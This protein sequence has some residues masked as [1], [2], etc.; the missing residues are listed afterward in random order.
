M[1]LPG[2]HM[3][4]D[5]LGALLLGCIRSIQ[6][7]HMFKAHG[8]VN[9]EQGVSLGSILQVFEYLTTDLKKY[10]D[11]NGKGPAHPLDHKLIKVGAAWS[12][13]DRC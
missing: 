9:L 11:R 6:R 13:L 12:F 3:I 7:D 1:P 4:H 8:V 2:K 10:M 5:M